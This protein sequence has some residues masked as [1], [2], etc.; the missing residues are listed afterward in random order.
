MLGKIESC[1]IFRVSI[2]RVSASNR[3]VEASGFGCRPAIQVEVCTAGLSVTMGT[4]LEG[5]LLK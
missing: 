2:L 3:G 5:E 1:F 4:S